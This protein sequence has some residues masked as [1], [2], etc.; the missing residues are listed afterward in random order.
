MSSIV[1]DN[2]TAPHIRRYYEWMLEH[3]DDDSLKGDYEIVVLP[4]P[5][6]AV[7]PSLRS[8]C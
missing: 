6:L 2:G 5:D 3:A 7:K 1:D 8:R 4:P